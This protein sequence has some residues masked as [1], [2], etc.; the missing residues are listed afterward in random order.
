MIRLALFAMLIGSVLAAEAAAQTYANPGAPSRYAPRVATVPQNAAAPQVAP[1]GQRPQGPAAQYQGQPTGQQSYPQQPVRPVAGQEP[2][3]QP[4]GP[5]G[6]VQPA[7]GPVQPAGG[8]VPPAAG[9]VANPAAMAGP[10]Q[11]D[12]VPLDPAHEQWVDQI[13]KF[14]E[15]RS[16]KIKT[17]SCK[18]TRWDYDPV[19]GPREPNVA[20]T[21]AKGE[22]K[23][24]QPDKGLFKVV[25]LM[26]Y[27]PPAKAGDPPTYVPQDATFGE[28][29]VCDGMRVFEFDAR[30]KRVIERPLPPNMQGKA[31]TDGPLPFLFGA[32]AQTIK[33]RYWVR[34]IQGGPANKYLLEAVPKSRQDAQNF[35]AV[36]IVLDQEKFLPEGMQILAPNFNARTNPAFTSYTFE[37]HEVTDTSINPLDWFN[38]WGLFKKNF[39]EPKIPAGWTKVV[40]GADGQAAQVPGSAPPA[41]ATAP[42][43][44]R[45]AF[46][47]LPR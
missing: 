13:L 19:F 36:K 1:A 15:E 42:Q 4:V 45:P 39:Y 9:P 17:L 2:I 23:Y 47:P 21:I 32:K 27:S 14:W 20:K 35:Q 12:W 25:E 30:N 8:P 16:N 10:A 34:G 11:P 22:I 6:P 38:F 7:G 41:Q 28:H 31:I 33:A 24:A 44:P 5:A 43:N 3:R 46:T 29:W 40:E 18:F 26:N 37:K